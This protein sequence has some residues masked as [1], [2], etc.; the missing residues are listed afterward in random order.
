MFDKYKLC[1]STARASKMNYSVIAISTANKANLMDLI[2]ATSLVI[3]KIR[4]KIVDF[5]ARVTMK[6]DGGP[7]KT[8]GIASIVRQNLCII[9]KPSVNSNCSYSPVTLNAG[10]NWRFVFPCDLQIWR[11]KI[12]G[13][14][15]SYYSN[16][17]ASLQSHHWIQTRITV[18]YSP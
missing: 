15:L 8:T 4:I 5:S 11:M 18:R 7:R 17:C 10:Q 2:A 6:F 16:L 9:A 13:A 12:N 1:Q 14:I 3:L